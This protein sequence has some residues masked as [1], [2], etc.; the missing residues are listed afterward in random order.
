MTDRWCWRRISCESRLVYDEGHC[1]PTTGHQSLVS[2]DA[3]CW[4]LDVSVWSL[5][6]YQE[7]SIE[8]Q[9]VLYKDLVSNIK[10]FS[11]KKLMVS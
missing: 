5:N 11:E 10:L 3:R 6:E 8:Y 7:S 2:H 4:I 1:L 9:V